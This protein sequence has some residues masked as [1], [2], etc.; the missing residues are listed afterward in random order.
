MN[1][2]LNYKL[3]TMPINSSGWTAI[4]S[5]GKPMSYIR[6]LSPSKVSPPLDTKTLVLLEAGSQCTIVIP[7]ILD[8]LEY[9]ESHVVEI[10]LGI[11]IVRKSKITGCKCI[12]DG[13]ELKNNQVSADGREML[14]VFSE[15]DSKY[16]VSLSQEGLLIVNKY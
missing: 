12:I 8:S 13:A 3:R 6:E 2:V 16:E 9:L 14:L 10:P 11:N 7:F 1:E 4:N 5:V 15:G